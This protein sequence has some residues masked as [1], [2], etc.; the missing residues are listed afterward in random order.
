MHIH[1]KYGNNIYQSAIREAVKECE[2]KT[3]IILLFGSL[4]HHK[5]PGYNYGG[6]I[7][8]FYGLTEQHAR[9]IRESLIAD[10]VPE[11]DIQEV[12]T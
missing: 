4:S 6:G 11:E 12:R 7:A 8:E 9:I 3:G 2:R 1:V 5:Q 10:K